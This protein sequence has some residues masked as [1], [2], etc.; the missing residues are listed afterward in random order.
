MESELTRWHFNQPQRGAVN[1]EPIVGEF[2]S[3]DVIRNETEALVRESIQNSLDAARNG[4]TVRVRFFVSGTSAA[5]SPERMSLYMTEGWSHF[6]AER[7][8]LRD[9]P[10]Q[11]Q[12]CPFLVIE[13]FG[14]TGLTGSIEQGWLEP[15]VRNPFYYFFRAEGQ[16]GKSER[17]RGRWGVGK[18]VFPRSSRI[19]T[20]FG[21]T[22]RQ[23]DQRRL[24]MGRA[25]LRSHY[26]DGAYFAPDGFLG[27]HDE[28]G[29]PLPVSV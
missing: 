14:T 17:D 27:K 20:F 13:D 9:Q 25:V 6:L 3:T 18:T 8:G 22:V 23:D 11:Q 29:F 19:K 5:L 10:D 26:V 7:N 24:M 12:P 16:S 15:A 21:L 4:E 2:F 1:R 28:D